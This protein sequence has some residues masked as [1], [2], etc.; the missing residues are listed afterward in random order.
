MLVH[1][2]KHC[3]STSF[4]HTP[5]P[6]ISLFISLPNLHCSFIAQNNLGTIFASGNPFDVTA[7]GQLDR[8]LQRILEDDSPVRSMFKNGPF[9]GKAPKYARAQLYMFAQTSY[10]DMQRTGNYWRKSLI[11]AYDFPSRCSEPAL[12]ERWLPYPGQLNP[13]ERWARRR[14][15]T[16]APLCWNGPASTG[17]SSGKSAI[18]TMK[19]LKGMA[20]PELQELWDVYWNEVIPGLKKVCDECLVSTSY[21][22]SSSSS[23]SSSSSSRASP[24]SVRGNWLPVVAY[25]VELERKYGALNVHRLD[26]IRGLV[27]TL[28]LE[29]MEPHLLA[30]RE[31]QFKVSSYFQAAVAGNSVMLG[32][33]EAVHKA[34]GD[35]VKVLGEVC[36][37]QAAE[38]LGLMMLIAFRPQTYML[39]ARKSRLAEVLYPKTPPPPDELP[40]FGK[41]MPKLAIVL[42]DE[43]DALPNA[44][45]AG[46]VDFLLWK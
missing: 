1:L 30:L 2:P 20:E 25:G 8:I 35:V 17:S 3:I 29:R 41:L 27:A 33:P 12:L 32:G 14:V 21:P 5:A 13:D 19:E 46:K 44:K 38:D 45:E 22:S 10:E 9:H 40:G 15:Q 37:S 36:A 16:L 34:Q 6:S 31:P 39:H 42:P 28:L 26:A 43:K 23:P 4:T 18:V 7:V 24:D 11:G